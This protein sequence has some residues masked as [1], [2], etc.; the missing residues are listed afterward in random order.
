MNLILHHTFCQNYVILS[1]PQKSPSLPEK[2]SHALNWIGVE[3]HADGEGDEFRVSRKVR[4][5]VAR[6][7]FSNKSTLEHLLLLLPARDEKVPQ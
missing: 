5:E 3:S 2:W 4:V 7:P 1:L 6:D